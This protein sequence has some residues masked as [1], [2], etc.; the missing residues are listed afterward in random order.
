MK[1]TRKRSPVND[2]SGILLQGP[3]RRNGER[4]DFPTLRPA[5]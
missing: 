1:K 2:A 4:R 3:G 5:S